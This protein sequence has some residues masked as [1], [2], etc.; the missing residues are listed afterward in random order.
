MADEFFTCLGDP[1]RIEV[2]RLTVIRP[3]Y[4]SEL[5]THFG[6]DLLGLEHGAQC[7]S[8]AVFF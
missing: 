5:A 7:P 1:K 2:M 3:W 8:H 4:S 6:R